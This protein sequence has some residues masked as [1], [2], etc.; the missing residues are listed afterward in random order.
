MIKSMLTWYL[1]FLIAFIS[2]VPRLDAAFV[3]SEMTTGASGDRHGE[4]E[5]IEAVLERKVVENRLLDLGFTIHEVENWQPG[6]KT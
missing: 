4:R 6:W 3:P 1:V 2:L 5:R